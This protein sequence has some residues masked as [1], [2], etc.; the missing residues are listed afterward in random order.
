MPIYD[1]HQKTLPSADELNGLFQQADK[2]YDPLED[3]LRL[4]RELAQ[5]EVEYGISSADFY[6]RYQ[7]GEIG[8]D[9]GYIAWAGRYRLYMKLKQAISESL[10]VVVAVADTPLS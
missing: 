5:M 7:S 10:R 4:E 3:L 2:N 8:D 6:E 9:I 1:F